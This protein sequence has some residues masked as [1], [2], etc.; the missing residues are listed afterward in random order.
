MEALGGVLWWQAEVRAMGV[1][2]GEALAIWREIGD[3]REIANALYNWSFSFAVAADPRSDPLDADPEGKGIA[4]QEEA[5]A[6]YR[7]IGDRRGEANVLWGIG[8]RDYFQK[9]TDAGTSKFRQTLEIFREVG[10]VTMEAWSLHMLGSGLARLNKIDEA[11]PILRH[12]L[13]HFYDAS[14]AAGIALLFD[15]LGSLA[16]ADGDVTRAARLHGAARRLTAATGAELAGFVALQF[17][18]GVRPHVM[19][20]LSPEELEQ[21]SAEGAA[22]PLDA[23]VA[24]ALDV[25]L[26]ELRVAHPPD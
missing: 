9:G 5:L 12:A 13:R 10:D 3:R 6:L 20:H 4:A 25:T 1:A 23:A 15:D 8:N 18:Q 26:E 19:D 2:Y 21:Q 11:R 24:Y 14:D 17:E 16:V 22:L 7:E